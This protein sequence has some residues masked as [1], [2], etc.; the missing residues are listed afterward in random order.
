MAVNECWEK[1]KCPKGYSPFEHAVAEAR[2]HHVPIKARFR[3]AET[4]SDAETLAALIHNLETLTLEPF[5][6]EETAAKVL[7]CTRHHARLILKT[8]LTARDLRIV[9]KAEPH[10]APV[11]CYLEPSTPEQQDLHRTSEL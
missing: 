10:K 6:S 4:Q 11:Y 8:L 2:L 9:Q 3:N 7:G 5:L 1:V